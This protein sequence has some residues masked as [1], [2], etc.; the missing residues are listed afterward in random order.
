MFTISLVAPKGGSGK[1]MV[2][3]GLAVA[4]AKAGH[5]VAVINVD[6]K[7]TAANWKD[8][9]KGD[10]P[11]VVAAQS[12]RLRQTLEAARNNG[13]DYAF[14][15][16]AGRFDDSALNAARVS[17]LVLVPTGLQPIFRQNWAQITPALRIAQRPL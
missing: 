2:V 3:V 7:F 16:T 11:A 10:H 15:D 1:S 12:S 4:A 13:V 6:P 5:T 14:V 17:D 9:R 8:R